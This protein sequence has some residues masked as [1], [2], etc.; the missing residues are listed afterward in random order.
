MQG[1]WE[2]NFYGMYAIAKGCRIARDTFG[3]ISEINSIGSRD[4]YSIYSTYIM[5]Q[6]ATD[7]S[8][9]WTMGY[10]HDPNLNTPFC[11]LILEPTISSQRPQ[12]VI[13]ASPN[14]TPPLQAVSFDISGSYHQDPGKF[15]VSWQLDWNNDGT[16]DA[17]G[18]FPQG[19]PVINTAGYPDTGADYTVNA[20]LKVT[21]NI[22]ETDNAV[23]TVSVST[24]N[25]PPVANPGGPYIGIVGSSITLDGSASYDPN[26]G[27]PLNDGIV[28][29]EWDINGDGVYGDL[30]K[31]IV[32]YYW[33]SP[34]VG[35]IGLKVTDKF[36]ASSISTSQAK[37]TITDLWPKGYK[38]VSQKR[39]GG[40]GTNIWEYTMSFTMENK[41]NGD[42]SNVN[43]TLNNWPSNIAVIDGSVSWPTIPGYSTVTAADTF[44][45]RVDRS[46]ATS[47][48][49]LTWIVQYD[50]A[51]GTHQTLVN[52]PFLP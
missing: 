46:V 8:W 28:S 14:P 24:L 33:G 29:W 1:G 30:T 23:V 45:L 49:N 21:D 11:I 3:N 44:K 18:A 38:V 20:L 47:K 2:S 13:T 6:Q 43:A 16:L 50:D 26:A 10:Y 5:N 7:G 27:P 39:I 51:G 34:Y 48:Y 9:G 32:N 19:T 17:S 42:A 35:V 12:A 37:V 40:R 4:W 22:G 52:F 41:G 36:G 31:K 25:V 15:L